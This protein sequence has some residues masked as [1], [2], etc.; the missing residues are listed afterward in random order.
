M[1][2][3][4]FVWNKASEYSIHDAIKD[5]DYHEFVCVMKDG[6]IAIF[7][8][9]AEEN[10]DGKVDIDDADDIDIWIEIPNIR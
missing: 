5:K 7:A 8:G 2:N 9:T 6:S 10:R 4:N 1:D 3:N